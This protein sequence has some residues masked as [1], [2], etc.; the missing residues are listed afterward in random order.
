MA[1]A[2]YEPDLSDKHGGHEELPSACG[3]LRSEDANLSRVLACEIVIR[4]GFLDIPSF[5]TLVQ[6]S[7]VFAARLLGQKRTWSDMLR[8]CCESSSQTAA[9][10]VCA[11]SA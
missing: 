7:R 11:V 8:M 5:F 3:M 2:F 1:A 4:H 9:L 10:F 6:I